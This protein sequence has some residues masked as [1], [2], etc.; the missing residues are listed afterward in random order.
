MEQ[1]RYPMRFT[2]TLYEMNYKKAL[3]HSVAKQRV[4]H[5]LWKTT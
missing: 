3:M 4:K 1:G 5:T 2:K